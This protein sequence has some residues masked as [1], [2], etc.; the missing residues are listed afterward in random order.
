MTWVLLIGLILR[1]VLSIQIYSGDVNNHISWGK[2]I[3]A[4]GSA[5]VYQREFMFRYGTLTPTYPPV[6]L[7]F[8]TISQG[9]FDTATRAAWTLNLKYPAFPSQII[10]WMQDQDTLPAFHKIWAILAD[11]GIAWLV[12]TTTR[13]RWL[14]ALV[15]FNPAIFLQQ[16][17]LGTNRIRAC[18]F[19]D[20]ILSY[21]PPVSFG[22]LFYPG[23][24]V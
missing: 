11:I 5:G 22:Y 21:P 20:V 18:I 3:L 4:L 12:Y 7:L 15:L 24:P 8:F 16:R 19:P 9:A 14:T 2:D 6:A 10:W 13:K 1:L 17:F 23:S